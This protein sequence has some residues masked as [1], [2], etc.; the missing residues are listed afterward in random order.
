MNTLFDTEFFYILFYPK[1]QL[2]ECDVYSENI[3]KV[4]ANHFK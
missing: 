2:L 1:A 3:G 4:A